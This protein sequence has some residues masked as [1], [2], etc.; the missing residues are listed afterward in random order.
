MRIFKGT[1][2]SRNIVIL[3]VLLVTGATSGAVVLLKGKPSA[4]TAHEAHR[5][6]VYHCPMH[7]AIVTDQPGQC[8]ICHMDLQKVDEE[9]EDGSGKNA[10]AAGTEQNKEVTGRAGFSLSSEKQQLIGV[11]TTKVEVRALGF[12][13]RATGRV[14]FDPELYTAVEEFRQAALTLSQMDGNP[15]PGLQEQGRELVS[16]AK[17]KLRLMGLGEV[18]IRELVKGNVDSMNLLLPKG[19]VWI[20]AEVFE[21]EVGGLKTGQ[22]LE[23]ATPSVPGKSFSGKILSIS[24]I[25]NSPTRT[26]RVRALVPD[27]QNLLRPDTFVNVKIKVDLG[28]RLAI[29]DDAI[30]HSGSETFVFIALGKGR[31]E[32]RIVTTGVKSDDSYEILSGLVDGDLVVSSANFLIDSES[33]LRSALKNMKS[34]STDSASKE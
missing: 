23:V 3:L 31:Y 20:Y 1:A 8:P 11:A 34:S 4:A 16:S 30:L 6:T 12:E 28:K 21:Y 9:G 19:A 32:P 33:R 17:T 5:K 29:P 2:P 18:Q 26:V 15:Y 7:P 24:P 10:H 14:A 13:V 25:V 22:Q 27:P